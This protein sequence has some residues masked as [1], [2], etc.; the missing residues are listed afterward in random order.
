MKHRPYDL[1][2]FDWDGTLMDSA[3][4][5]VRCFQSAATD[6]GVPPPSDQEIR[7]IIGLGL[8]EALDILLPVV[9]EP[10]RAHVVERYR[11]HFI[12]IDTTETPLFPG[13]RE[14]L[15]DLTNAGYQLAIA[16]GK[17]RRGLDRVL[18]ETAI[19]HYFCA[20]RCADESRS[21]PHPQMLHDLLEHT[22]IAPD[23][24][25]MVGDT[26]YDLEMAGAAAMSG[27]AVCYGAHERGRLLMHKPLE[28]FDSFISVCQWLKPVND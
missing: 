20:T 28:C 16:T 6:A 15:D 13:V 7:N 25:L 22:G 14:G 1:I 21:K 5:I 18:Q 11:H 2:V 26:T 3:A 19:S 8:K 9:D 4:K 10:A 27:I 24:A 12:H 23:R 17:A